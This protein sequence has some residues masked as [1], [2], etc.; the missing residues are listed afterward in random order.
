MFMRVRALLSLEFI[1][2]AL[3]YLVPFLQ[4]KT[5]STTV[6]DPRHLKVEE[7]ISLTKK[8]CIIINIQKIQLNLYIH[9]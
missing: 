3:H 6:V 4:F 8:Y 2:D 9:S 1:C 7:D 5:R